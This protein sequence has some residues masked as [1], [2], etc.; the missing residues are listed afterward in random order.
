MVSHAAE[1]NRPIWLC[2]VGIHREILPLDDMLGY[3]IP[4]CGIVPCFEAAFWVP[5]PHPTS[6]LSYFRALT[7]VNM[8][9]SCKFCGT[10]RNRKGLPFTTSGLLHHQIDCGQTS[11][12]I[13]DFVD[14]D[15]DSEVDKSDT[16]FDQIDQ[17]LHTEW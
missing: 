3:A 5:H 15:L 4:R 9:I 1:W 11:K 2:S 6:R 13:D 17:A 10:S 14:F 16:V 7:E 12:P 8:L